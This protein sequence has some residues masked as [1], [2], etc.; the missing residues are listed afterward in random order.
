M[1]GFRNSKIDQSSPRWFSIGV[2]LIA[3]R[4]LPRE[5]PGGLGGLAVGVLDRLRFVENDV[6]ELDLGQLGDVGAEGA[7]GGDDQVVVGERLAEGVAAGAGV[8]E[9]AE[10]GGEPCG[11]RRS[12]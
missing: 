2:P 4:C 11:L 1:P 12:S 6:V 9:N 7:V 3:S 10:P 5:Q 8:V